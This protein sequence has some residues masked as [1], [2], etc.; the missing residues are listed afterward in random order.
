MV[1]YS[2]QYSASTTALVAVAAAILLV[3]LRSDNGDVRGNVTETS[4]PFTFFRD[5]SKGPSYLKEGD[6]VGAEEKGPRP[7]SDRDGRIYRLARSQVN[8]KF[9]LFMQGW[10]RIVQKSVVHVQNCCFAH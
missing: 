3:T 7:S 6:W 4:H 9:G 2:P 1:R 5:Y 10:Q 8:L